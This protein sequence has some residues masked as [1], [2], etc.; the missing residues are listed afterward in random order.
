MVSRAFQA[1]AARRSALA[2]KEKGFTLIELLVVVIIIGV[3][4]AIAIP[5]YMNVQDSAKDSAVQSDLTNAKTAVVSFQTTGGKLPKDD[6]EFQ[7]MAGYKVPA[8]LVY[9]PNG[10]GFCIDGTSASSGA[11]PFSIDDAG[12]AKAGK[13]A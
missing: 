5:V 1:L 10:T 7:G 13:C 11:K 12:A 2:E 9:K 3:L 4:A 6:V 8:G